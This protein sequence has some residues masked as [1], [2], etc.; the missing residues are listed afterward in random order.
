MLKSGDSVVARV[1]YQPV[2]MLV[3]YRLVYAEI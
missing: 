1:I 2:A 3:R